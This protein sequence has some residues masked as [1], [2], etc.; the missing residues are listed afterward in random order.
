MSF[1]RLNTN[2][3]NYFVVLSILDIGLRNT[4][5]YEV[6]DKNKPPLMKFAEWS[7]GRIIYIHLRAKLVVGYA[8]CFGVDSAVVAHQFRHFKRF[9]QRTLY[10]P[11]LIL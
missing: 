5:M 3:T 8:K 6:K 9:R 1:L 4:M 10:S 7:A 2:Q 11:Y